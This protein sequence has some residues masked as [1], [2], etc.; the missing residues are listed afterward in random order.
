MDYS[1]GLNNPLYE[2]NPFDQIQ[3]R[4]VEELRVAHEERII[5]R[6]EEHGFVFKTYQEL[7]DFAKEKCTIFIKDKHSH[8]NVEGV[9]IIAFWKTHTELE[10]DMNVDDENHRITMKWR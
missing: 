3:K 9:G 4:M 10:F 8:L 5:K 7:C 2:T 6:L 1:E